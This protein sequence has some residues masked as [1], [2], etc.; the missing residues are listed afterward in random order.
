MLL[1][2]KYLCPACFKQFANDIVECP[3]CKYNSNKKNNP[4]ISCALPV[5]TVLNG[6]YAVGKVLGK[7]GFGITY[8]AY[9]IRTGNKKAIKEFFPNDVVFRTAGQNMVSM[10]SRDKIPLFQ[11]GAEKFYNEAKM[12]ASF[13]NYPNIINVEEFFYEN[14]TVYFSM[15]YLDGMDLR[16][17]LIQNKGRISKEIATYILYE[18]AKAL[19]CV[20]AHGVL[21]RDIAPDNIY[22]CFD[23]RIKLIDF[24]SARKY[25]DD[26]NAGLSVLIKRGYA[27]FEQYQRSGNQGAWTDIYSLGATIYNAVSGNMLPDAAKR[28]VGAPVIYQPE[29]FSLELASI[30]D[31]MIK[32]E[33]SERYK[34]TDELFNAL[35]SF[36]LPQALPFKKNEKPSGK[37]NSSGSNN[38]TPVSNGNNTSNDDI[39]SLLKILLVCGGIALFALIVIIIILLLL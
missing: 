23:G 3:H 28:M 26:Q 7:G 38:V 18:T 13:S 15:E 17:Y 20:H 5:E 34:S 16:K 12:L 24:G 29:Y 22:L 9:D 27:P 30:I 14:G 25:M 33:I 2:G 1:N 19:S 37:T 31:K 10:C 36:N 11:T 21:H 39:S 32:P 4:N 6:R 8:L 35:N